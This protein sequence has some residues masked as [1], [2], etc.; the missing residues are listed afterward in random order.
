MPQGDQTQPQRFD[1]ACLCG[2]MMY[3]CPGCQALLAAGREPRPFPA[4]PIL[5]R[6]SAESQDVR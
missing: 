3:S 6:R 1:G 4:L 5:P 2:Q